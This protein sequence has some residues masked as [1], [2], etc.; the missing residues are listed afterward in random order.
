MYLQ[1]A[2]PKTA[3]E[4]LNRMTEVE[5]CQLRAAQ[6]VDRVEYLRQTSFGSDCISPLEMGIAW[7]MVNEQF[8]AQ[9]AEAGFGCTWKF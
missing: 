5:K 4:L 6:T 7:R 3:Q 9:S 8:T 1:E 2:T